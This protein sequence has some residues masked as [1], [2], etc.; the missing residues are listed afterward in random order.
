MTTPVCPDGFAA[1][2]QLRD[3]LADAL[4]LTDALLRNAAAAAPGTQAHHAPDG[5]DEDAAN[6]P[7]SLGQDLPQPVPA[8]DARS[9][10]SRVSAVSAHSSWSRAPAQ[11]PPPVQA[12][13]AD[14]AAGLAPASLPAS[15]APAG[16]TAPG[17]ARAA[18]ADWTES[19]SRISRASKYS[20][21]R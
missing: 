21:T 8:L 14:A 13:Q 7:S 12:P 2:S 18:S 19:L 5:H 10:I 17:A 3:K 6:P 15:V 9:R 20:T 16:A 11:Q 1:L 4:Q